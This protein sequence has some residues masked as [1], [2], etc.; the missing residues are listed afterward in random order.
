MQAVDRAGRRPGFRLTQDPDLHLEIDGRRIEPS[1]RH[2]LTYFF[3]LPAGPAS[4]RI[5]S[6]AGVP[7]ELG[8]ARDPRSL[9]IALRQIAVRRGWRFQVMPAADALLTDGFHA[10]EPDSGLRWT[11]GDATLPAALL[12]HCRRKADLV[13][14]VGGTTHYRLDEQATCAA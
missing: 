12:Q 9:G 8:V 5:I 1:A 6:R 10:F 13:L 7:A 4:V 14:Y 2:H 11:D 3:P